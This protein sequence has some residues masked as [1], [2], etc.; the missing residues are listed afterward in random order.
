MLPIMPKV[1]SFPN[2]GDL[3]DLLFC[4]EISWKERYF[5]EEL[6]PSL[7]ATCRDSNN[8]H[9]AH[10]EKKDNMFINGNTQARVRFRDPFGD[11]GQYGFEWPTSRVT[12]ER[13]KSSERLG[14]NTMLRLY[15]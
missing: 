7:I 11:P 2:T 4:Q 15:G 14:Q 1:Y 5:C 12:E 10:P 13:R 3:F 8:V 6:D 9:G